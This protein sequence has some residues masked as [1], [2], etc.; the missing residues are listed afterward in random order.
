MAAL[1]TASMGLAAATV[2]AAGDKDIHGKAAPGKRV[3]TM[4]AIEPKGGTTLDKEPFPQQAL[5]GGGYLL[6]KPDASGRWEVSTY[7]WLPSQVIVNQ[8]DEVTLE[9]IGINGDEHPAVIE[10]YGVSFVVKRGQVA[11][12][13]VR[14]RQ[15]RRIPDP[16]RQAS[17]LDAWGADRPG[18]AAG[19][20]VARTSG[21]APIGL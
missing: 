3:I 4:A 2:A 12:R 13:C 17:S 6:K 14:G 11:R 15:S 5:P 1:V 16:V 19:I 20:Q 21:S 9:I 18:R 8:G 10:G 7:R